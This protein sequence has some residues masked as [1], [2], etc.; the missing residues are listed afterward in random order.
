MMRKFLLSKSQEKNDYELLS[1]L[2]S[3]L[4]TSTMDGLKY[5]LTELYMGLLDP[6]ATEYKIEFVEVFFDK[7]LPLLIDFLVKPLP[8]DRSLM[9]SHSISQHQILDLLT[10]CVKSHKLKMR[11]FIVRF[12]MLVVL[13][14]LYTSPR[15]EIVL[16]NIRLMRVVIETN[17]EPI[18][19]HIIK[20][21]LFK[22]LIE[23]ASKIRRQNII[24]S[25]I[26]DLFNYIT[27]VE[28]T[29]IIEYLKD[30]YMEEINHGKYSDKTIFDIL[31]SNIKNMTIKIQLD[32]RTIAIVNEQTRKEETTLSSVLYTL[33]IE[34]K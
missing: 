1:I 27:K 31:R 30:K 4:E 32:R 12:E 33:I 7:F 21:D 5:C 25:A 9:E 15:K 11:Y 19:R 2:L 22:P 26:L 10:Y 3:L 13:Q 20:N 23:F 28:I 34:T 29:T 17:D 14:K 24:Y 18:Y 16:D 8:P 6:D